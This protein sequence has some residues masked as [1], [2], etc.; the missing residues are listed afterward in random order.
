MGCVGAKRH[1]AL[2]CVRDGMCV[3]VFLCQGEVLNKLFSY[4]LISF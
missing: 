3:C 4:V 1:Q 2:T